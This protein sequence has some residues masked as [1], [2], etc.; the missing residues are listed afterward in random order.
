VLGTALMK[1]DLNQQLDCH[2]KD[3]IFSS[4]FISGIDFI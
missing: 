2:P 4:F 3:N 1:P